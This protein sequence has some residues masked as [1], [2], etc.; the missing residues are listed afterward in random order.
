VVVPPL[1]G[2]VRREHV[3]V[4]VPDAV[5]GTIIPITVRLPLASN[6]NVEFIALPLTVAEPDL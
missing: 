2:G 3:D 1:G 4:W 5:A 6:E